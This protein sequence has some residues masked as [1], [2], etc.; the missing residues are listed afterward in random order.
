MAGLK[1]P[2]EKDSYADDTGKIADRRDEM[3]EIQDRYM[4]WWDSRLDSLVRL[5]TNSLKHA[6]EETP[7]ERAKRAQKASAETAREPLDPNS[8]RYC[9]KRLAMVR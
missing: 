3:Q 7:E 4:D 5:D 6:I 1:R 9:I 2:R 8:V